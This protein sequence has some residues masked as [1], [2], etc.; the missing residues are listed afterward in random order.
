MATVYKLEDINQDEL[1]AFCKQL[2]NEKTH[3]AYKNMWVDDWEND[4]SNLLYLI[5]IKKRLKEPKG[6]FYVLKIENKIV[7]VA[8]VYIS[9]FDSRVAIGGVRSWVVEEYRSKFLIGKHILPCQLQWAK[10][11][12]CALFFLTFNNYNKNLINIVKRTGFGRKKQRTPDMLFYN[13]VH[14]AP[15]SCKIQSPEQWVVYD[16]ID[17]TYEFD[18]NKIKYRN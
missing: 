15:F 1:L 18:W 7:A 4:K 2:S 6:Q 16:I 8:G 13:G 3:P 14:I 5:Y 17:D 11:K 10:E 9:D 12:N